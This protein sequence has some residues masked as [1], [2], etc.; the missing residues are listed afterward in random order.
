MYL[1]TPSSLAD[2]QNHHANIGC[3][4]LVA[5]QYIYHKEGETW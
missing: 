5:T 4:D 1:K 2:T 3:L